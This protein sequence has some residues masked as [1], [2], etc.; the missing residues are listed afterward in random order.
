[1]ILIRL[2]NQG[3]KNRFELFQSINSKNKQDYHFH[4]FSL[5]IIKIIE[6]VLLFNVIEKATDKLGDNTISYFTLTSF[7]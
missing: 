2:V 1:M 7:I 4:S 6:D 5:K 3:N